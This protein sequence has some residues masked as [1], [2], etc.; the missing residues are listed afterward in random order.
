MVLVVGGDYDTSNK[1]E[2]VKG[3]NSL[4]RIKRNPK[5]AWMQDEPNV[6]ISLQNSIIICVY[7]AEC[8][9]LN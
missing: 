1:L 5:Y 8:G 6:R 2:S 3:G 9:K 4:Y 7:G